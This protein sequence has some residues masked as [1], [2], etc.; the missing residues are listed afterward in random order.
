ML[1]IRCH[2]HP[3]YSAIKKPDDTCEACKLLYALTH[4]TEG[5]QKTL[6]GEVDSELVT[7]VGADKWSIALECLETG[8]KSGLHV[9]CLHHNYRA[10]RKPGWN[11]DACWLL[12]V[13]K[14][15]MHEDGERR[16]GPFN[17]YAYVID[18]VDLEKACQNLKV[19]TE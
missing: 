13:L 10:T 11:C 14:Y 8:K 16:L 17:P 3:R 18:H 12:F 9:K 5:D 4:Q 19:T 15:Q 1:T 6:L 2:L 7:T